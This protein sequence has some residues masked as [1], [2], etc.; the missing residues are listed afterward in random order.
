MERASSTHY[1]NEGYRLP[2][3]KQQGR[4][5]GTRSSKNYMLPN[6]YSSPVTLTP[7]D[8]NSPLERYEPWLM[9]REWWLAAAGTLYIVALGFGM[10]AEHAE[11]MGLVGYNESMTSSDWWTAFDDFQLASLQTK[12]IWPFTYVATMGALMA[13]A[14]P[15]IQR[16]YQTR[17]PTICLW[18]YFLS[19]MLSGGFIGLLVLPFLPFSSLDGE[20]LSDGVGQWGA[21]GFWGYAVLLIACATRGHQTKG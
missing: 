16:L 18:L 7:S 11:H 5:F 14:S 10:I 20:A 6:P 19:L 1:L 9:T 17:F 8:H 21:V 2:P 15:L 12:I 3:K 13:I 4:N